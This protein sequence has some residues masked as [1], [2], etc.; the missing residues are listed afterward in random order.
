MMYVYIYVCTYMFLY[1]WYM[2]VNT[3]VDSRVQPQ[4][5]F[6]LRHGPPWLLRQR[7]SLSRGWPIRNCL[8]VLPQHWD[9]AQCLLGAEFHSKHFT[10][11][12]T[13]G[14]SAVVLT[15]T[16]TKEACGGVGRGIVSVSNLSLRE[17]KAET[18]RLK[19]RSQRNAGPWLASSAP[20]IYL[21][22]ALQV[23]L[24]KHG[25]AHS[26]LGPPTAISSQNKMS[27]RHIQ[28]QDWWRKSL[29]WDPS[30]Q[31]CLALCLY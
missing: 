19:Q 11:W 26:G 27:H 3:Y 24:P 8:S 10:M 16:V 18:W 23:L 1:I 15:S 6:F 9:T 29:D 7:P 17:A 20:P 21:V 30:S 5:S 2:C 25:P 13:S 31:V 22:I 28:R 12:S 14:P 4:V